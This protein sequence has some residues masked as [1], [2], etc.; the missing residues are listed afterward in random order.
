MVASVPALYQRLLK[1]AATYQELGNR[2]L[3]QIEAA[4]AFKQTE[5]VKE[6]AGILARIPIREYQLAAEYHLVLCKCRE[7]EYQSEVLEQIAERSQGLKAKALVSRG[8]IEFYQD[9]FEGALYFYTEALKPAS[10]ISDFIKASTGIATVKSTEGYHAS[11]IR[12]LEGLI[13]L[14]TYADPLTY[15]QMVNSYAVE[16][17]EAGRLA[18]AQGVA[19]I[20]ASSPLG[21]FRPEWGETFSDVQ[22]RSRKRSTVTISRQIEA[23]EPEIE[24]STITKARVEAAIEFMN[25]NYHRKIVLG[26]MTKT[27]NLST[28]RFTHIFRIETG[29]TPID[30]LIRLRLEKA[31][32]LLKSSFLSVKQ[33]MAAVGYNNKSNFARHF[34]RQFGATPS[35]Y[36]DRFFYRP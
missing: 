3:G 14:L 13:P 11:A 29:F 24:L 2:V 30:Y 19:L 7:R 26:D 4:N 12:D 27:V 35:E 23:Y 22:L 21:P 36:R 9:N 15:F 32:N 25:E 17:L 31:S 33:V 18:E 10:T 5:T 16:L 8:A 28:D 6:L 34:K 20:A 1:G